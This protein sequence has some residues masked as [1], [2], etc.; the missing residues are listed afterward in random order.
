MWRQ[1]RGFEIECER[2]TWRKNRDTILG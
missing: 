1:N 2:S